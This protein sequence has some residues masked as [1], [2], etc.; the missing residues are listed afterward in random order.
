MTKT[1]QNEEASLIINNFTVPSPTPL[2]PVLRVLRPLSICHLQ[3][4]Q[5]LRTSRKIAPSRRQVSTISCRQYL[6]FIP[7]LQASI[8]SILCKV[9]CVT[10]AL[11]GVMPVMPIAW[12][13]FRP[14]KTQQ[15]SLLHLTNIHHQWMAHLVDMTRET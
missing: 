13:C 2:Y 15:H 12:R 5:S 10:Q 4:C 9:H 7:H 6:R 3:Q 11:S 8:M 1:R 14:R